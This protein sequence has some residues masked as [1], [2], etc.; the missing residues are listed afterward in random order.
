[1]TFVGGQA[2]IVLREA[3]GRRAGRVDLA[4]DAVARARLAHGARVAA[5]QREHV[6]PALHVHVRPEPRLDAHL[7]AG[8][9]ERRAVGAHVRGREHAVLPVGHRR[10]GAQ[11]DGLGAV[12]R[13][14]RRSSASPLSQGIAASPGMPSQSSSPHVAI[15]PSLPWSTSMAPGFTLGSQSLQSPCARRPAVLVHVGVGVGDVAVDRPARRARRAVPEAA[16]RAGAAARA[17]GARAAGGAAARRATVRPDAGEAGGRRAGARRHRDER[18]RRGAEDPD[19]RVE[20]RISHGARSVRP[21][22]GAA[23]SRTWQ[24]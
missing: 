11:L 22:G 5:R 12:G 24:R 2:G 9:R 21:A 6:L 1:M 13:G 8:A 10:R 4:R 3:G 17:R 20:L 15:P 19:A 7:Q 14:R 18:S 16:G 23:V